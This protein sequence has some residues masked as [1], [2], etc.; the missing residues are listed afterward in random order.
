MTES[1]VKDRVR[2]E[3]RK[4]GSLRELSRQ[5][6]VSPSLLCHLLNDRVAPGPKILEPLGLER[7]ETVDYRPRPGGERQRYDRGT[8]SS[9][10][11]V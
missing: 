9:D 3:I 6:G 2:V 8:L 1:E 7:I 10:A 11:H 4:A 5:W